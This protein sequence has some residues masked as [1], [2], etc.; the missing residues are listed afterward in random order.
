MHW[1]VLP[2]RPRE[3]SVMLKLNT[4]A[5]I[6]KATSDWCRRWAREHQSNISAL[7]SEMR[8]SRCEI[9]EHITPGNQW[10]KYQPCIVRNFRRVSVKGFGVGC[11]F[12]FSHFFSFFIFVNQDPEPWAHRGGRREPKT[13]HRLYS[14]SNACRGE[15]A[16]PQLQTHRTGGFLQVFAKAL[17][18]YCSTARL[19]STALGM[20]TVLL[21]CL[22]L[23]AVH[24]FWPG[25][26]VIKPHYHM[27]WH[28]II[29]H[30][31]Y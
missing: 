13:D 28:Q 21:M 26:P 17:Q 7:F 2:Q 16:L 10:V 9:Q 6:L 25:A 11:F 3:S 27:G 4:K 29:Q 14:L 15:E 30:G 18:P 1:W 19:C 24:P 12:H 31:S 20:H 8:W 22:S 5:S 23:S